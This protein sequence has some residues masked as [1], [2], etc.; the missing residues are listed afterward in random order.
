MP[1]TASE[2]M[3]KQLPVLS[4][5]LDPNSADYAQT[6]DQ[7]HWDLCENTG[8][9]HEHNATCF[10]YIP[11]RIK[12]PVDPDKDCRFELPRPLVSETH[13]DE[14]GDLQI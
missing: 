4:R 8:V 5:P 9:V 6:R 1:Y 13:F 11:R 14:D 2:G 7:W 12:R 3:P 10:K